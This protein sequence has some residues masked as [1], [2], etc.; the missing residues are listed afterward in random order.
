M[1]QKKLLQACL[2]VFLF[3]LTNFVLAQDIKVAVKLAKMEAKKTNEKD[4]DEL[5]FS[6]VE[7]S[8]RAAPTLDRIPM[9]PTN[10]LSKNLDNLQDV[11]LWQGTL[12]TS[13]SVLLVLSLIEQD[14]PPWD[15]DDHIG[16]VQVKLANKDDK[17][18]VEWGQP[19]YRDQPK[20]VQADLAVPRFEMFG[21]GA[22]YVTLFKIDVEK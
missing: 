22:R 10:W 3:S 20:V 11:I 13:Q 7:Y 17:L 15:N 18:Q 1:L 6:I 14:V 21:A 19:Q 9:F 5:Y 12:S 2:V 4:G 8:S 16:S